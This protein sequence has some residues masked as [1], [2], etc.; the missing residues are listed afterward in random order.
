MDE[1]GSGTIGVEEL[2]EPMLAL[3]LA[4]NKEQVQQLF[5]QVDKDQSGEIEF[6]EFLAIVRRGEHNSPIGN[7]FRGITKGKLM[8]GSNLLPFKLVVS[9]YRRKMIMDAVMGND[10]AQKMKGEKLMKATAKLIEN[11]TEKIKAKHPEY[12]KRRTMNRLYDING[13]K[14]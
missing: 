5:S 13:L 8:P 4:E 3:G 7:F 6:N 9:N 11:E 14:K 12:V 2:M 10:P 1:D